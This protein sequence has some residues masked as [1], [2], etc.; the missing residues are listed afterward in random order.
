MD[1]NQELISRRKKLE[2]EKANLKRLKHA[3]QAEAKRAAD[4]A[5]QDTSKRASQ[6]EIPGV[7]VTSASSVIPMPQVEVDLPPVPGIDTSRFRT[8]G[9]PKTFA[10]VL[11][12]SRFTYE[13]DS[14]RMGDEAEAFESAADGNPEHEGADELPAKALGSRMTLRHEQWA[15]HR[16]VNTVRFHPKHGDVLLTAHG[17]STAA[18][19]EN[20][21]GVVNMWTLA[22]G[23][24][25]LQ[26][27]L[28]ANA[29][30]TSLLL[31]VMAPAMVLGGTMSGDILAWD[32]RSRASTPSQRAGCLSKDPDFS[33]SCSPICS[34]E[35]AP[36]NKTEYISAS[37]NGTMCVWSPSNLDRPVTRFQVRNT[38]LT[39]TVRLGA[40]AVP[41][42]KK[43]VGS[44]RDR[45]GAQYLF[46]GGEDGVVY[47]FENKT[48]SWSVGGEI[49][50]HDA[51]ITNISLH[52]PSR[53]WPHL[54][55]VV[56]SASM[57]WTVKLSSAGP[58]SSDEAPKSYSLAMPGMIRD[59]KWSPV[60][61]CIFATGDEAGGVSLFDAERSFMN[62]APPTCRRMLNE[63]GSNADRSPSI[64][65][66]EWANDGQQ[67]AAGDIE[68][69][70][71][72]WQCSSK[73]VNSSPQEWERM[74]FFLKKKRVT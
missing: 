20:P 19:A 47:R 72:V 29:S 69:N 15:A 38:A 68:G 42:S 74:S 34:L 11:G 46:G 9:P 26:R 61:P 14:L 37:A 8:E 60:S 44:G 52:P 28:V 53:K 70:V 39:G 23:D 43:L 56:L 64:S 27:T 49:R 3:R 66:L 57:D 54:G 40:I 67:L 17:S 59:V 21:G 10:D 32:L 12:D 5:A 4:E 62:S 51:P 13:D 50:A 25:R 35:V 18:T 58:G 71:S 48:D 31:P 41:T 6:T 36:S 24:S 30:M 16:P 45:Q 73:V 7:V 33:H 22:G 63:T 2:E 55:D 65:A 1:L